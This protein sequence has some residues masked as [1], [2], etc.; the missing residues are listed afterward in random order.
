MRACVCRVC[1]TKL[2]SL[3]RFRSNES[4]KS[5]SYVWFTF[6]FKKWYS[7]KW[8][9]LESWAAREKYMNTINSNQFHAAS[10]FQMPTRIDVVRHVH[11]TDA[12]WV[13]SCAK[14]FHFIFSFCSS[15]CA[16]IVLW[17]IGI[18]SRIVN[19]VSWL[20]WRETEVDVFVIRH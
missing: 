19:T 9:A 12:I 1:K 4:E 14:L 10:N 13:M 8:Q 17:K 3:G 2:Q 6:F 20:C 15:R 18:R 11:C 5:L 7:C 16:G